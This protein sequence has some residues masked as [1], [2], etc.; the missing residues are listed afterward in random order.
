[1]N[2]GYAIN[3]CEARLGLRDHLDMRH[4]GVAYRLS[5]GH[6]GS[7]GMLLTRCGLL[8]RLSLPRTM[9]ARTGDEV[10]KVVLA[11]RAPD[12]SSPDAFGSKAGPSRT[13]SQILRRHQV[14]QLCDYDPIA[15]GVIRAS[16]QNATR[17]E[18]AQTGGLVRAEAKKF[19]GVPAGDSWT[20]HGR[21]SASISRSRRA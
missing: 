16:K 1:M 18:R 9:P 7:T 14:P 15:G 3:L 19:G 13:V 17:Y 21:G 4:H 6:L 5:G 11:A 20:A 2:Q 8:I 10:E 12:R